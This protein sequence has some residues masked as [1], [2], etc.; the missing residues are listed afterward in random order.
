MGEDAIRVRW[1]RD[2]EGGEW[3]GYCSLGMTGLAD[4]LFC[5]VSRCPGGW[6]ADVV[7][8]DVDDLVLVFPKLAQ[9]KAWGIE[10]LIGLPLAA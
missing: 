6:S 8:G 9:A 10:Q 1:G 4:Q 2:R 7:R 5:I 3:L